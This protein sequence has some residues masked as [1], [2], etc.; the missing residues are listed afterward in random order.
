MRNHSKGSVSVPGIE[1]I[2]HVVELGAPGVGKGL[3]ASTLQD[4]FRSSMALVSLGAKTRERLDS[5]PG[6]SEKHG[7][8]VE[9]GDLLPDWVANPMARSAYMQAVETDGV[10][11]IL[12]DGIFRRKSQLVP[13]VQSSILNPG[14]TIV[15][16]LD[17]TKD[18]CHRRYKERATRLGQA[19]P[20]HS[21]FQHRFKV[22]NEH[23]PSIWELFHLAGIH[24]LRIDANEDLATRVAPHVLSIA[25][26]FFHTNIVSPH[27]RLST[28]PN[29][30]D[31]VAGFD[32]NQMGMD[33]QMDRAVA[34]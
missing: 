14:N 33:M 21:S 28:F 2:K 12:C 4:F 34:G 22:F 8:T 3:C 16:Y 7:K 6:F 27:P 23:F 20:D 30:P 1:N 29:S 5:D 31:L 24:C 26:N 18:T 19:R 32:P 17:A 15:L 9:K 13:F 25:Q 11:N 10:R